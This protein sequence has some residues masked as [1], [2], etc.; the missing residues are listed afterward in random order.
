MAQQSRVGK[1][2]TTICTTE[3]WTIITYHNTQVVRFNADF[4]VLNTGGWKTA[5]TKTRMNQSSN[6]FELGYYVKQVGGQWYVD[7]KGGCNDFNGDKI[8]LAR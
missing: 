1:T 3:G 8:T 5:T 2:A 4:I 6:Q 7:F